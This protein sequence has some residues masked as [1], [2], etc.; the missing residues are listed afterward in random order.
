VLFGRA[1]GNLLHFICQCRARDLAYP[2][3]ASNAPVDRARAKHRNYDTKFAS[4]APVEPFVR[5]RLCY[6]TT[7]SSVRQILR[8]GLT[9]LRLAQATSFRGSDFS[10]HSITLPCLLHQRR[11]TLR[12]TGRAS[13]TGLTLRNL[14]RALRSNQLLDGAHVR[15]FRLQACA[16]DKAASYARSGWRTRPRLL[17]QPLAPTASRIH[18][19]FISGV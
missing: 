4:R 17:L 6:A 12:L 16:R 3:K 10:I 18:A 15:A 5:R 7:P 9:S 2:R 11:L 13:G 14:L 8:G 1:E 19:Y